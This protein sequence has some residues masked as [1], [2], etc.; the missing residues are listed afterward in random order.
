MTNMRLYIDIP[1]ECNDTGEDE[2]TR[3]YCKLKKFTD[4]ANIIIRELE[5]RIASL[6]KEMEETR[7]VIAKNKS[8][9]TG[10]EV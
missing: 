8:S 9:D 7:Y 4:D 6:E 1:K 3:L 10:T 5:R 2:V